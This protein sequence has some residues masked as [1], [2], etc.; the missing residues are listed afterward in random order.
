MVFYGM[1]YYSCSGTRSTRSLSVCQPRYYD[2]QHILFNDAASLM[3]LLY[4]YGVYKSEGEGRWKQKNQV[5]YKITCYKC[6]R[7]NR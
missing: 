7:I 2:V 4:D 6:D 1:L 3:L 5:A